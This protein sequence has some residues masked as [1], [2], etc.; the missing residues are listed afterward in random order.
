[1]NFQK[2]KKN[3]IHM[4]KIVLLYYYLLHIGLPIPGFIPGWNS[5][6]IVALCCSE[7]LLLSC[8]FPPTVL[9]LCILLHFSGRC[10]H[11]CCIY[12]AAYVL[13]CEFD[14]KLVVH[15]MRIHLGT[16]GQWVG[17][18]VVYLTDTDLEQLLSW[19][20]CFWKTRGMSVSFCRFAAAPMKHYTDRSMNRV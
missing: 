5:R 12:C 19:Q 8:L 15:E 3:S 7:K 11:V 1:M 13:C 20:A 4:S 17:I 2:K 16:F 9:T 10:V 6:N 14:W 18:R